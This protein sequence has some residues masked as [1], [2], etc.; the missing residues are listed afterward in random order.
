MEEHLSIQELEGYRQGTL[1][2]HGLLAADDHLAACAPCQARFTDAVPTV[3]A[4]Q[5][6]CAALP[7]NAEPDTHLSY[8][9]LVAYVDAQLNETERLIAARHL[10]V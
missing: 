9:Q 2:P 7:L 5:T 10:E 8:E 6:L 1:P 4:W 3:T